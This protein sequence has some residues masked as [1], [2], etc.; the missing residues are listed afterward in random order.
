ML[1]SSFGKEDIVPFGPRSEEKIYRENSHTGLSKNDCL[2][3]L[4][5][6][7]EAYADELSP[8]SEIHP[9]WIVKELENESPKIIGIIL[10]WL[11]SRHVRYILENLPKRIKLNLPKLVD[12]FAVPT[13]MLNVIRTRFERKFSTQESMG[14]ADVGDFEDIFML[15]PNNLEKL[16]KDLGIHELAMAFQ[17]VDAGGVRVLL[18]RMSVTSARAL[19]QRMKDVADTDA[20]I[21]KDARFTI[22]EVAIDQEDVEKLLLEV[23]LAAFSKTMNKE[24]MFS[25]IQMKLDPTVSYIFKRY[26]DQYA[27]VNKLW[28]ERQELV[29]KRLRL[30]ARAGEIVV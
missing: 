26:I 22:L 19:Q 23:G 12:S 24:D 20:A 27:G 1:I 9:A 16:F 30:L 6:N 8:L 10:R 7:L 28:K 21:L 17:N 15:D 5:E 14:I 29:M 4:K 2:T 3:V 11:P 13:E 25:R 18:N